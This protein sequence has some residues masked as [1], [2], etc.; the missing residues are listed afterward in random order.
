MMDAL[1]P[2]HVPA[3]EVR[4]QRMLIK[5]RKKLDGRINQIKNAIRALFVNQGFEIDS[6]KRAWCLGRQL[7]DS[8]RK[9]LEECGD[10]AEKMHK[11]DTKLVRNEAV[12]TYLMR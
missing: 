5:Y 3:P 1:A 10:L 6:G 4:Q 8:F 11:R 9:P 12:N 2:V 7:I